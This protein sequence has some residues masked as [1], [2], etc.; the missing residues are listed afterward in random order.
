MKVRLA[1]APCL[2][3]ALILAG[4]SGSG[5]AA[6]PYS[7]RILQAYEHTESDYLKKILEDGEISSSE[8]RDA[9]E[10]FISCLRA[11]GIEARYV[12]DGNGIQALESVT[13]GGGEPSQVESDC[14]SQW[15]GQVEEIYIDQVV[16][17]GNRDMNGLI[18]ECLV[19]KD[20]VAPGFS[21]SD[22]KELLHSDGESVQATRNASSSFTRTEVDGEGE[23]VQLPGGT[24]LTD[25]QVTSCLVNPT[26]AL[27]ESVG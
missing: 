2:I 15:M 7:E 18:A 14:Y 5:D 10:Q 17:P 13:E 26:S 27:E 22:L 23:D 8:Y 3:F 20:L 11:G 4:C 24:S 1:L 9:Q 12:E 6:S 21:G 25:P 19:A 16:N